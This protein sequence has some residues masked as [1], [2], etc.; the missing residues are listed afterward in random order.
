MKKL[1]FIIVFILV[2]VN[3]LLSQNYTI[4]NKSISISLT[5]NDSINNAI[6]NHILLDSTL[7][8]KCD[9]LSIGGE[10]SELPMNIY[11][12]YW[13]TSL[14]ITTSTKPVSI[15]KNFSKFMFLRDLMIFTQVAQMA[16]DIQLE[17]I[18]SIWSIG[19]FWTEFPKVICNWTTLKEIR[20][21]DGNFSTIPKQIDNLENLMVL[22]LEN[23]NIRFIPKELYNLHNLISLVLNNNKIDVI[24]PNICNMRSL[25]YVHFDKNEK[26][27]LSKATKNCLKGKIISNLDI[28]SNDE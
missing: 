9:L 2:N 26:L 3:F 18:E 19:A 24:S 16:D 28:K 21:C 27:K 14:E 12:L 1:I 25:K 7:A 4:N 22:G 20:I 6:V 5:D 15:D 17:N 11:N 10:F 23:N 8:K 13:I